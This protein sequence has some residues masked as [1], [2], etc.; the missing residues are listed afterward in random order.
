[1]DSKD[2]NLRIYSTNF[3]L[4]FNSPVREKKLKGWFETMNIQ[5][6]QNKLE[7]PHKLE[8]QNIRDNNNQSQL[9]GSSLS[10]AMEA[11]AA[12]RN[13]LEQISKK[14]PHTGDTDYLD[15]CG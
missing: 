2:F 14:I 4:V 1:M 7:A 11:P 6:G 13:R 15:K 9:T 8:C 3:D 5:L 12:V 10:S